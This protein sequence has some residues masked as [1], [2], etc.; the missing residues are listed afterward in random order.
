[1][2]NLN[3]SVWYYGK[4]VTSIES[5]SDIYPFDGTAKSAEFK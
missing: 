5:I 1:M 2:N 4:N 3:Y